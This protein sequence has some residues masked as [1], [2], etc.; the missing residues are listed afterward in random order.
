LL[1]A[2]G[3]LSIAYQTVGNNQVLAGVPQLVSYQGITAF[4][5]PFVDGLMYIDATSGAVLSSSVKTQITEQQAIEVAAAYLGVKNTSTAAVKK[6]SIN[7]NDVYKVFISN[8]VLV[9]DKFGTITTL[10]VIQYNSS[11]SSSSSSHPS[12]T[13]PPSDDHEPESDD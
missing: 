8:Y 10:Q 1:T 4:E 3:A 7:G 5:I 9:V 2:D 11:S 13:P 6:L 12:S